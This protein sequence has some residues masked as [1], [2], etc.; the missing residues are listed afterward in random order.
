AAARDNAQAIG[1]LE[2][3]I[4]QRRAE[5]HAA[6]LRRAVLQ[7]EIEMSR[8]PDAAVR[9]LALDPDFEELVF[10]KVANTNG[11]FG[12]AQDPSGLD[13]GAW[14]NRGL[15]GRF[16]LLLGLLLKRTIEQV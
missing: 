6:D 12:D 16:G 5:D 1:G 14:R 7:R 11:Q 3:E 13:G 15:V 9:E 8:V 10:E 4:A 2:L